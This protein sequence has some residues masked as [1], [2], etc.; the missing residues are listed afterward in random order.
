M[1]NRNL[2]LIFFSL[3]AIIAVVGLVLVGSGSFLTGKATDNW[4]PDD[5]GNSLTGNVIY[6]YPDG[7][8]LDL[9]VQCSRGKIPLCT[10][11]TM[12]DYRGMCRGGVPALCKTLPTQ[13]GVVS[14]QPIERPL[15]RQKCSV[16]DEDVG[17]VKL[18]TDS[19][20]KTPYCNLNSIVSWTCNGN[21]A[22]TV[23]TPCGKSATCKTV[24]N[25]ATCETKCK[26]TCP[27]SST[28]TSP[29]GGGD[30]GCGKTCPTFTDYKCW[31]K[32][33]GKSVQGKC[34]KAGTCVVPLSAT[35]PTRP[36]IPTTPPTGPVSQP[37]VSRKTCTDSDNGNNP[38]V[39]GS[40][41]TKDESIRVGEKYTPY[42]HTYKDTC[43]GTVGVNEMA[44][45]PDGSYQSLY[46][47]CSSGTKCVTD[48]YTGAGYCSK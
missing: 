13:T 38:A 29:C 18:S 1:E 31:E 14:T 5:N 42:Y 41:E 39:A 17:I 27:R 20:P 9:E 15:S 12:P 48:K 22:V 26:S 37:V 32:R 2:A 24:G 7:T 35:I 34:N 47:T 45:K 33:D 25:T 23:S 10:G 44:C 11:N 43:I 3:V 4:K 6:S 16:L 30:D 40:V 28:T 21:R 19:K 8:E 46:K 36:T